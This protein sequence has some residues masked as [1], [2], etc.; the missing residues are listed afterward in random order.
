MSVIHPLMLFSCSVAV[1]AGFLSCHSDEP[2]KSEELIR[3]VRSQ[4]VF[5]SGSNQDRTFSGTARGGLE[6]KLSFKVSGTLDKIYIKVGDRLRQGQ[7]VAK[8]DPRDYALQVQR[9][10]ASLARSKATAR[11][12]AADYTR[13]R[14]LYENRNASRTDLDEARAGAEASR[15]EVSSTRKDLELARLQLAYTKLVSPA[16]CSVATVPVEVNEN[17]LAN[18]STITEVICG[19]RLEVEVSIPEVFIARV[20]KGSTVEVT[21]DAIPGLRFSAIVTKVGVASGQT[22]TTFPVTVQ[23]QQNIPGFRSGMAADVT[24]HFKSKKGRARILVPPV[25]VGEDRE[26]RYV[27]VVETT[28]DG[29]GLVHRKPVTVGELTAEGL[30]IL[31]GLSDGERLVTAG[32]RRLHD[33]RKVRLMDSPQTSS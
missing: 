11:N 27:Y 15:A 30:E 23:L 22:A 13:V 21:F 8:L 25:A 18:V 12:A 3:P 28:E 1:L 17:I 20:K 2:T 16:A 29:F 31:D 32:V 14:A 10:E 33:G 26:G 9:A 4:Q 24:F 19:S 5:L 6:A 7:I